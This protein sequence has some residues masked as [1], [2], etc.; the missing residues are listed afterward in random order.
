MGL[1]TGMLDDLI[2]AREPLTEDEKINAALWAVE[3]MEGVTLDYDDPETRA[4]GKEISDNADRQMASFVD[5][6]I[7]AYDKAPP[8]PPAKREGDDPLFKNLLSTLTHPN[9]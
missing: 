3:K 4:M 6:I 9:K 8:P 7:Q 2:K 1:L 5:S